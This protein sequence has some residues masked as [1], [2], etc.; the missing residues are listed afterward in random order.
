MLLTFEI[1][2]GPTLQKD[3][4][5]PGQAQLSHLQQRIAHAFL[6][7]WRVSLLLQQLREDQ[8]PALLAGS[9]T[10][11]Q[12]AEQRK[13]ELTGASG[14]SLCALSQASTQAAH[15]LWGTT[16]SWSKALSDFKAILQHAVK[17]LALPHLLS[18]HLEGSPKA[19]TLPRQNYLLSASWAWTLFHM[20][21]QL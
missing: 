10:V 3:S 19:L 11:H 2:V 7:E 20:L 8:D 13:W 21:P 9:R 6:V 12:E 17:V 4:S 18:H 5:C 15:A 16:L 1:E 14:P